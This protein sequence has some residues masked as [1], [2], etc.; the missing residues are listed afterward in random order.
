M[1]RGSKRLRRL[2]PF[3]FHPS[4]CRKSS[5]LLGRRSVDLSHFFGKRKILE[6]RDLK[7]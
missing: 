6:E 1:K 2:P 4:C 3:L 7:N 5:N